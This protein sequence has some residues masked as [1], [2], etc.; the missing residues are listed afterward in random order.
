VPRAGTRKPQWQRARAAYQVYGCLWEP[1]FVSWN[2]GSKDV[3][4]LNREKKT[5]N[6][7]V[8]LPSVCWP[9]SS[10]VFDQT[11]GKRRLHVTMEFTLLCQVGETAGNLILQ[12]VCWTVHLCNP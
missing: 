9:T 4:T 11:H 1:P 8:L 6:A 7:T 5:G 2:T 12:F 3:E 10:A